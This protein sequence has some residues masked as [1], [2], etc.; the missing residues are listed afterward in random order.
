MLTISHSL[1][2]I[3]QKVRNSQKPFFRPSIDT[4]VHSEELAVLMERCW[5]QEP[6]ERPDFSQIK[7]FI[8]R[9]NK[10]VADKRERWPWVGA[11]TAMGAVVGRHLFPRCQLPAPRQGGQHQHPGQPAVTH[12]AVCQQPGEAGGGADAGLPGGE[13]QGREPPLPDSAPVRAGEWAGI[14]S[15][16]TRCYASM[17]SFAGHPHWCKARGKWDQGNWNGSPLLSPL[18]SPALWRSS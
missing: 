7:I 1:A 10:W 8:R 15:A 13:A 2:E 4:G 14:G 9:F 12:G 6:A 11:G 17:G 18:S 5:A 3:V 16:W